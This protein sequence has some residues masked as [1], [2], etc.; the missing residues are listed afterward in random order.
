MKKSGFRSMTAFLLAMITLLLAAC[1]AAGVETSTEGAA[2]GD[3]EPV[4]DLRQ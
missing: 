3:T 2:K 4:T 1:T